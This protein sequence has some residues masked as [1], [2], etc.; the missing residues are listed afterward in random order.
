[1]QEATITITC[2]QGR[3]PPFAELALESLYGSLYSSI[4]KLRLHGELDTATTYAAWRGSEL[5]MVLLFRQQEGNIIVL[6]EGMQLEA[7]DIETF[8]H[9]A[10]SKLDGVN[11]IH[12][13]A[14]AP[15]R[16]SYSRPALC[17]PCTEDIVIHLPNSEEDYLNRLGKSTRKSTRQSLARA[18][19]T[20][21]AFRHEVRPGKEVSE[22]VLRDII[23]FNHA[24]MAL[25]QRTSAINS[26]ASDKLIALIHERGVVGMASVEGRLCGGTL[27]CRIGNDLHSLVNAHN[28]AYDAF[29]LGRVCRHLMIV[30]AIQMQLQRFHLMGGQFASKR[31]VLG[32]RQPLYHLAFYRSRVQQLLQL[33]DI[34][35]VLLR[36]A[37]YQ[38]QAWLEHQESSHDQPLPS[39][40]I[41]G[42]LQ[43]MRTLKRYALEQMQLRQA[44]ARL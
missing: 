20:L 39:K 13:H 14:V 10:F 19:R 31:M 7:N 26:E 17:L 6:N 3:I 34:A 18:Q 1:M 27:A 21:P 9:F 22:Q 4:S 8:I 44:S 37:A 30:Y 38:M 28:P 33:G 40:I 2:Y 5:V 24:R 11:S 29:G 23:G 12:F 36:S 25:K 43:G 16:I 15:E 41:A 32:E 35:P 42:G